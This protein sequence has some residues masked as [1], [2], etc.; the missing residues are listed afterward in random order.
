M[1][2]DS[3]FYRGRI[4]HARILLAEQDLDAIV[5]GQPANRE[6]LSGFT[7]HDESSSASVGWIV[8]TPT[9]GLLLTNFNHAEAAAANI[10][11][12]EIVCAT[13]RLI[14][15]LVDLL[16]KLTARRIGFESEWLNVS[17]YEYLAEK[18]S[19]DQTLFAVDGLI[20]D[21]R[22]TKDADEIGRIRQSIALT[23]EAY[24]EVV[25][26][27]RPGQTERQVAWTLERA[28]RERGADG[29]AFGPSVAAGG[30]AAIPHH[31]VTDYAIQLGDP[32]WIDFGA[33]LGGYC[34]DLTRSFCLGHASTDYLESWNLVL[35]AE[36]IALA[37]L[38]EGLTGKMVDAL[39]RDRLEL[40]G[41]AAEFGHGLGH[42]L[43]LMIH[44][45]PR[46]SP[47][48]DDVM[49]SGMV[50]TI[51]PGLYRPGWGG[52]RIED[53]ALVQPN[54]CLILSNAP[55]SPVI[56]VDQP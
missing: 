38:R 42:G 23:D 25:G 33:R 6:Y 24:R 16:G 46:V 26:G 9:D 28:L 35:D 11:H 44:E 4:E 55:K 34:A 27:L 3:E 29:V 41:R 1:G 37:G 18:V 51:E 32:V 45:A 49:R 20:E 21:L 2:R 15:G 22:V 40:A 47:S 14:D 8:L 48:S 7:W 5:I 54:G 17:T 30:N 31:E 43:G 13:A 36:T 19:S 52:V 56:S 39:A 53:V 10:R 12:L 50:V